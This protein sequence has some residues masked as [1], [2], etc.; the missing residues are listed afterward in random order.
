[1]SRSI[2]IQP[3]V[4]QDIDQVYRYF[5]E[6]DR[7]RA[8]AFFD[9]VRQTFAELARM[10]GM[11]KMYDSSEDDINDLRCWFVKGFK[12]F[13]ILYRFDDEVVTIVRVIDGRR[14]IPA[15]LDDL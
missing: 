9:A 11:G 8:M 10:P 12:T 15:I 1:M 14:D 5:A 7:D 2:S 13:L 6:T 3:K 4:S